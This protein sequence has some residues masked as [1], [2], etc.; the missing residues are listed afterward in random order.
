[1]KRQLHKR[2][3]P[4]PPESE[5]WG[6][7][8]G[9]S[10]VNA[11]AESRLGLLL[12]GL[13][14]L[15]GATTTV[16]NSAFAQEP[17]TTCAPAVGRIVSLQGNVE[18]QRAGGTAWVPVRR[19][20]TALCAGDRLRTD[21]LSRS[22]LFVQP[23]SFVRVD[24]NTT[25]A[26]NQST[27][28]IEVQFFACELAQTSNTRS[29]GAGYFITRFPKKFKVSTPHMNA[30]VEGTEFMVESSRDAT[31]LTV[32]EGKVS[33][34]SVATRDTQ[35]VTAGQSLQSGTAG[36]AAITAIVRPQDA[37]QWVLR[38]PPLR[39]VS[40]AE[41]IPSDEKCREEPVLSRS[42]CLTE[43]AEALLRRGHVEEALVGID[44]ALSLDSRNSDASALRAIVQIAKNDRAAALAAASTAIAANPNS[45]RAWLAQSYAQQAAFNLNGALDSAA[46]ARSLQPHSSI[47]QTRVAELLLSLG[48]KRGAAAAAR[49]AVEANPRES[50]AHTMLGYVEL[51]QIDTAAARR[52]FE[53]A[54]E[55]DSFAAMP[56]LGL[57]LTMIR[58]GDL[59]DGREQLEIAV[60]LDPSNSLIRSYA[61]K[62]YY[63]ENEDSRD[64]LAASQFELAKQ[65][66]A[67]DPTP[68][69]YDAI[70][71]ESGNKPV[72]ALHGLQ[73]SIARND[74]RAVYRSRLLVDD[75][76]AGRTAS[77]ANIYENLGFEKLAVVEST[78]A[79][80]ESPGNY[81]A[82]RQLASAYAN[83]PRHDIARVSEELQAQIR[84]PVSLSY[85]GPQ[86][87]TDNL[88]ISKD[89]GPARPGTN[90]FN[91]L[92]NRNDVRAQFDG[93][94]GGRDTFGDQFVA[95]ML[96]DKFSYTLNQLHYETDGFVENDAAEKDIYGL[97]VHGQVTAGSSFQLEAKRS[98]L[99]VGETF[100]SFDE[101]AFPVTI[102]D[103]SD[104]IRLSG[105]HDL[106]TGGNWIWSGIV[107]NRERDVRSYPDGALFTNSEANPFALE[108]QY[109][110]VVGPLEIV[111]GAGYV[112]EVERFELQLVDIHSESAN[113]YVYS[114]WNSGNYPLSVQVG[115]AGEWLK[116]RSF[117]ELS[118]DRDPVDRNQLSPKLGILWSL[119]SD[120]TL[121]AA[122][123]SA[124]RRPFIRSQTIEP[125]QVAGFN[126]FFKGF[127]QFYGDVNGFVSDRVGAAIDHQF[128]PTAF[129]GIEVSYR[130]ITVPDFSLDRDFDWYEK[131]A[132]AYVYKT[133]APITGKRA[134]LNWEMSLSADLEYETI[135]RP[136]IVTGAEG[137]MELDTLRAPLGLRLFNGRGTTLRLAT[138]YVKQDGVFSIGVDFPIVEKKDDAWITDIS[139]E[140]RLPRR[141]GS[142]SIGARNIFDNAIDLL[143]IDPLNPRVATRQFVYGNFKLVF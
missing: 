127:E 50:S 28:E 83:L 118:P 38:Y 108:L 135:D 85:V 70:L 72:M 68:W 7:K 60:A 42:A 64:E 113:A 37:V 89:S 45:A 103:R 27:D 13:V 140:Q 57:G 34:E 59:T 46:K 53:S 77:A 124:V 114:Q 130:E 139:I 115:L 93:V 5:P 56:R 4:E 98:D 54:I 94:V 125:T 39:D 52:E 25:I 82:H 44:Q 20:D 15:A 128:S 61:G 84:Q 35:L 26:L 95:S 122:A 88:G 9:R 75:D 109:S 62:A 126:Q 22:L 30:A 11:P 18:V 48:N 107:E 49:A 129:G 14:L 12:T 78:R 142:V 104:T 17:A 21:A 101:F 86:L 117:S 74:N 138:T 71:A 23:E 16:G 19:L 121:R 79:L 105:Y 66:D 76:A 90:E 8:M 31:K 143:E 55:F 97:L 133:L 65:L 111:A 2:T 63:E 137:I 40:A 92:F 67:Q 91:A 119:G 141:R 24:Q 29:C 47:M 87:G 51:A 116:V 73:A 81:S 110:G 32:L 69:F 1:L 80:A 102:G 6:G 112:Q 43:R 120:T 36:P 10:E 58:E 134:L 99:E 106:E 3:M 132:H 136:Q 131:T 123:F 96:A 33:S 100:A 41:V